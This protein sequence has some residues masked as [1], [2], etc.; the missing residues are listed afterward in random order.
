MML[1][2]GESEIV[3]STSS[4]GTR[5]QLEGWEFHLTVISTFPELVLS[6]RTAGTKLEKKNNRMEIQ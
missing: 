2:S 1:Y 5:Y 4:G 3:M 6:E